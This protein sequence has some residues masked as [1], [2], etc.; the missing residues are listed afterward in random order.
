MTTIEITKDN[1]EQ[2]VTNSDIPVILDFWASW[3][4][5]CRMM[6]PIY[7]ELSKEYEGR[8]KFGKIN[9]ESEIELSNFF[10][11]RSIPTF[12]MMYNKKAVWQNSGYMSKDT[13]KMSIDGVLE[14][15][16]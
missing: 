2:E 14:R 16:K 8:I 9:T 10:N 13:L 6:S 15:I 3:C 4:G 12:T 1:I 5:P 7:E 11:I